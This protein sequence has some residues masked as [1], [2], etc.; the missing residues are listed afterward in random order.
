MIIAI[1]NHGLPEIYIFIVIQTP[2]LFLKAI[3]ECNLLYKQ[4]DKLA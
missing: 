1:F 3:E 2:H 4:S